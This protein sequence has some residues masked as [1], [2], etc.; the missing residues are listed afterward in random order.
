MEMWLFSHLCTPMSCPMTFFLFFPCIIWWLKY[1]SVD[2]KQETRILLILSHHFLTIFADFFNIWLFG[3][4][5]PF[6]TP[7]GW[8]PITSDPNFNFYIPCTL[9]SYGRHSQW[10]LSMIISQFFWS[11][12]FST[13]GHFEASGPPIWGVYGY[14]WNLSYGAET[15]R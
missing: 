15:N 3:P 7:Y 6:C 1:R 2:F 12:H 13:Y 5:G 14:E 9:S 4:F 10:I 11:V 8:P